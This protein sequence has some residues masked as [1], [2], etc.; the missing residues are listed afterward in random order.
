MKN[1]NFKKLDMKLLASVLFSLMVLP[2]FA[3]NPGQ[4][5]HN[6]VKQVQNTSLRSV[7][8]K[9]IDGATKKDLPGVR[10]QAYNNSQY[11]A[12]TDEQGL[13]T[14]MVPDFVR[15]LS[16]Q[17]DGYGLIVSPIASTGKQPMVL[18]YSEAFSESYAHTMQASKKKVAIL[19][20]LNAD[21]TVDQQIQTQLGGD[22]RTM[23]RSGQK[24]MGSM[25]L[26]NG[27]Q[28]LA[29]NAQPLVVVDGV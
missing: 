8:G 9:V 17:A 18:L 23:V 25:M 15:S 22:V 16:F 21:L 20:D 1:N 5:A 27:I 6:E 4:S 19:N 24:A 26:M 11:A 7:S 13:F 29:A 12:M 28:S 10:I 3:Q 14:L 2:V